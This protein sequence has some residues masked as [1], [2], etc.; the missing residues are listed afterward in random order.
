MPRMVLEAGIVN[1]LNG[2]MPLEE[3]RN[4][5]RAFILKSDTKG[6]S[7]HAAMEQGSRMW[8]ERTTQS[9]QPMLDPA[10]EIAASDDRPGDNVGMAVE[11]LRTTVQ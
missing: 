2:W 5:Q 10:H 3:L 6:E 7:L 9:I 11:I 4:R 1:R 8:I